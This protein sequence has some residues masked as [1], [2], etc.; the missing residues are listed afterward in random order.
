M[1]KSEDGGNWGLNAMLF[2]TIL[3]TAIATAAATQ[4]AIF[5]KERLASNYEGRFSALYA[6]LFFEEYASDCSRRLSE[7]EA[8]IS[9]GGHDGINHSAIPKL[10]SFP[11]EVDWHR[12]GIELTEIAFAYRV[13]RQAASDEIADL[14]S[15]DPPDGGDYELTIQLIK[16]GLKALN[17]AGKIRK[18]RHLNSAAAPNSEYTVLRYLNERKAHWERLKIETVGK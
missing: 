8:F 11:K 12:I 14:Y 13:E 4:G 9:S 7:N 1:G 10:P 17:I 18:D 15:Y 6:A 2:L 3:G 16:L 5:I